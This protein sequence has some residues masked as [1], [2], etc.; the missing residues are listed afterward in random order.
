MVR[1]PKG[2]ARCCHRAA[3]NRSIGASVV[4]Q[5]SAS[6][7]IP[8]SP[9]E[10]WQLIGGFNSLRKDFSGVRDELVISSKAGYEMWP[11]PYGI[12]ASK[13]YLIASVDQSLRR[14]GVDYV[15]IFYAHRP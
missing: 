14:L 8:A 9:N 10:V 6:I 12:G 7:E 5:A 11:G 1:N 13:K 3:T 15:D 2:Q 4:A